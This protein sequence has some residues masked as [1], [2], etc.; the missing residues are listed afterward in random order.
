MH[1]NADLDA[2]ASAVYLKEYFGN[3][4]LA[5][6][7][8]DR[9]S[10][11]LVKKFGIE[12]TDSPE[13]EFEEIITVD[14]A[15]FQQLG[16]FSNMP[17]DTVYDHHESNNMDAKNRYVDP[18]YPSCAEMLYEMLKFKPSKNTTYLL[19]GAIIMDTQWFRHANT[20]T[21][22]IF[23]ELLSLHNISMEEVND[24]L[25]DHITFGERISV[26]KGFQRM[27][28]RTVGDKIVCVTFVSA[29][30]SICATTLLQFCDVVF[31]ASQKKDTVRIT[32]R[33]KELSLLDIFQELERDFSC[34]YGG[35]KKAAGANCKGDKEALTNALLVIT[36]HYLEGQRR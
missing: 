24:I 34:T 28:Y 19:L 16:K 29:N 23:H 3:A 7:G 18:S 6:D 21:F 27:R 9:I 32:G 4:V 22:R 30:E 20:N 36:S 14:T 17:V 33:A 26:L 31:V 11:A 35:H 10:R 15:S 13:G 5:S 12:V 25:D 1:K 2:L 8:M